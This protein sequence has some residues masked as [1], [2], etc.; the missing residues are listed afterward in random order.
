MLK[1]LHNKTRVLATHQLQFLPGADGIIL[2]EH[3][4]IVMFD[5][6]QDLIASRPEYGH[7][8]AT[9]DSSTTEES[10]ERELARRMSS[11][12]SRVSSPLII[13]DIIKQLKLAAYTQTFI[14]FYRT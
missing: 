3:G 13:I 11:M 9:N 6:Y 1:Y 5:N 12:S 2:V 14:S 4:K 8:V 7:L 10:R